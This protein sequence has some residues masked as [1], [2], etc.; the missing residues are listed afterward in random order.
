MSTVLLKKSHLIALAC[1]GLDIGGWTKKTTARKHR[2]N[3]ILIRTWN[4][5]HKKPH[6]RKYVKN[7]LS[8]NY[9]NMQNHTSHFTTLWV[10]VTRVIDVSNALPRV[11]YWALC[12]ADEVLHSFLFLPLCWLYFCFSIGVAACLCNILFDTNWSV[13]PISYL[14]LPIWHAI[15]I[16]QFD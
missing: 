11:I 7:R 4:V 15:D 8:F 16:F 2:I 10:H 1:H 9:W 14:I 3:Q 13:F 5:A 6:R 12:S